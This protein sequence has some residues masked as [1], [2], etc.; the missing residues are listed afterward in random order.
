[1]FFTLLL[2]LS[3]RVLVCYDSKHVFV[4]DLHDLRTHIRLI[5]I[6]ASEC[7]IFRDRRPPFSAY[8]YNSLV[9]CV[10]HRN[11]YIFQTAK[12]ARASQDTLI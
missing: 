4:W 12:D 7:G 10:G 9:A 1:M 3:E 5:G 6:I 8:P 11:A 2:Q